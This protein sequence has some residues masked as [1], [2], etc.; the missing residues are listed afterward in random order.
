MSQVRVQ[1]SVLDLS[2]AQAVLPVLSHSEP[3]LSSAS[4]L[5]LWET[6]GQGDHGE[7]SAHQ[8]LGS[9]F[10]G[11]ILSFS[12][13]HAGNPLLGTVKCLWFEKLGGIIEPYCD[14]LRTNKTRGDWVYN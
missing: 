5:R 10:P 3:L 2:G 13:V 14:N 6:P 9:P 11:E 8:E 4:A 7:P 1:G 12:P